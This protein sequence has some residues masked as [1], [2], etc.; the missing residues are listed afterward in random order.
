M[1]N[2][3]VNTAVNPSPAV[4]ATT[5]KSS[6]S[7]GAGAAGSSVGLPQLLLRALLTAPAKKQSPERAGGLQNRITHA[8]ISM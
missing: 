6:Q 5:D 4:L 3:A 7:P 2:P 1:R 8:K